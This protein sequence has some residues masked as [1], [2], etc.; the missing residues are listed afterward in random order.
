M[1]KQAASGGTLTLYPM[2]DVQLTDTDLA[3]YCGI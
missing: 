2:A 1:E 3:A